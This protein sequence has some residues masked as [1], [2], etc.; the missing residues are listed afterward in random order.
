MQK[1]F[2]IKYLCFAF[3]VFFITLLFISNFIY[4]PMTVQL[5]LGFLSVGFIFSYER[6]SNERD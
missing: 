1:A 4:C 2:M 3:S 6:Y 5:I